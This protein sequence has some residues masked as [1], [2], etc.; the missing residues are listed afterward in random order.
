MAGGGESERQ[1]CDTLAASAKLRVEDVQ[2][3]AAIVL[4]PKG[5]HDI[6]SIR[7]EAHRADTMFH[8]HAGEGTE[9]CGL[10]SL[11]RLPSVQ[12]SVTEGKKEVRILVTTSNPAE[13]KDLRRVAREQVQNLSQR[14]R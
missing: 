4:T 1:L 9:A 6:S 13:V 5:G 3:G 14:G 10:F 11:G 8:Q 7:D 2:N 12:T